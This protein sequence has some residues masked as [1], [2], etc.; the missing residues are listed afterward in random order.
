[1]LLRE[2]SDGRLV[3]CLLSGSA[4][5]A[6]RKPENPAPRSEENIVDIAMSCAVE[7]LAAVQATVEATRGSNLDREHGIEIEGMICRAQGKLSLLQVA[8]SEACR[9]NRPAE[10]VAPR[11]G[12]ED[13]PANGP[14]YRRAEHPRSNGSEQTGNRL[15]TEEASGGILTGILGRVR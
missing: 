10:M 14:T 11:D 8:L 5:V 1:M 3:D 6:V 15:L 13:K 9:V 2:L 4:F 7:T 12:Q